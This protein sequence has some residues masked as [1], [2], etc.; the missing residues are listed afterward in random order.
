M[1][2]ATLIAGKLQRPWGTKPTPRF[3]RSQGG[4]RSMVSPLNTIWPSNSRLV[5]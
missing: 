3:N 5:P 1:F 2:S 4:K